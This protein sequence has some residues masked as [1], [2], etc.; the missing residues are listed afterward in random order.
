MGVTPVKAGGAPTLESKPTT[1]AIT[2]PA[3]D[4]KSKS[5]GKKK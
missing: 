2:T 5:K 4:S 1:P 3:T